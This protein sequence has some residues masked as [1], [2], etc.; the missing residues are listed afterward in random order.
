MSETAYE[1]VTGLVEGWN[2]N[3]KALC[4]AHPDRN[5]SLS[6]TQGDG[7]ALLHCF[8]GCKVESIVDVLGLQLADL[9]DEPL[10]QRDAKPPDHWYTYHDADGTSAYLRK[11]YYVWLKELGRWD[12]R[13]SPYHLDRTT[14]GMPPGQR[15]L[16]YRL[17]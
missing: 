15:H 4:P 9:W 13:F 3:G 8:A 12:K 10:A 16:L 14:V 2:G 1:R 6:I 7:R 17:P 11:R 5:P